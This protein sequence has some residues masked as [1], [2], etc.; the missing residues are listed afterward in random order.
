MENDRHFDE[1]LDIHA[2]VLLKRGKGRIQ[3]QQHIGGDEEI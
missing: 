1:G 3:Q 2:C